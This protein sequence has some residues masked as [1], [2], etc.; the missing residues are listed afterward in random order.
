M[1]I[2]KTVRL[3]EVGHKVGCCN[4]CEKKF[5]S[6]DMVDIDNH[7]QIRCPTCQQYIFN[8]SGIRLR[9]C[10]PI[11]MR[12]FVFYYVY[13]HTEGHSNFVKTFDQ[14]GEICMGVPEFPKKSMI[15][16]IIRTN[17]NANVKI[18]GWKEFESLEDYTAYNN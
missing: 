9:R 3:G 11:L 5:D 4:K 1:E 13:K 6:S 16:R 2:M 10:Q 7:H 14:Y 17:C 12:Y 15:I 8:D 18:I